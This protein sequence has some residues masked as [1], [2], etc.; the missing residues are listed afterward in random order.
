MKHDSPSET[1]PWLPALWA[2]VAVSVGVVAFWAF[3]LVAVEPAGG[4]EPASA[5]APQANPAAP[6]Q[7]EPAEPTTQGEA[8]AQPS[9]AG[10][11]PAKAGDSA[12]TPEGW[13]PRLFTD[14][15]FRVRLD[16]SWGV[17]IG[18]AGLRVL[19]PEERFFVL[20]TPA[21]IQFGAVSPPPGN[22]EVALA[23]R[24]SGT[25]VLCTVDPGASDTVRKLA[26]QVCETVTD[27][28][29]LGVLTGFK[30]E[31]DEDIDIDATGAAV[32]AVR[33]EIIGCF[34]VAHRSEIEMSVGQASVAIEPSPDGVPMTILV[35]GDVPTERSFNWL[36]GCLTDLFRK[37]KVTKEKEG[38]GMLRCEFNWSIE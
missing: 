7:S 21:P 2:A 38:M 9:K 17:D 32:E 3:G 6:A 10:E 26:A 22:Q 1:R 27:Q 28:G 34:T 31:S 16:P 19:L 37:V 33:D 36:K 30:C 14:H 13:K 23:R 24:I 12:A 35:G 25:D 5:A 18:A 11:A 15:G 4:S 29:R 8:A 20:R